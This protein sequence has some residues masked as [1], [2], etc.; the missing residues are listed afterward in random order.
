MMAMARYIIKNQRIALLIIGFIIP[1]ILFGA[2]TNIIFNVNMKYM[3][4][5]G[6]FN[7]KVDFVDLA[8]TFN[9]WGSTRLSD[10]DGDLIYSVQIPLTIGSV[11]QFKARINGLWNGLEEFP[12]GGPNRSY[13]VENNGVVSFWYNDQIPPEILQV[14]FQTNNR[15]VLIDQKIQ[16]A[17][18]T[19]QSDISYFW[20]LPGSNIQTSTES[21][22]VVSYT[23]PGSYPVNLKVTNKTGDTASV[24]ISNYIH[25]M[26]AI[27]HWWNDRVFYE[28]FVR[29]FYDSNGDGKGDLKGLIS[30]LDY[31][32]DGD[33]TTNT[34][35][36]ITGIW[37]M[38]VMQSPS[39]HGYDVTDYRTVETDY[40]NNDDFKAFMEAAHQRGIKVI[41]DLVMNHTSSQHPW[42]L[43][44][45]AS[46]SS[47]YRNWYRW[48]TSSP[49]STWYLRNGAYYYG[50][51]YSGMPDLNYEN[52][53]VK[54]EMFDIARYWL[55]DMNA[56]GFRLDAV[57]YIYESGNTVEDLPET[58]QFWKDFRS[59][60][61]TVNPEAFAVAEAWTST[62]IVKNYVGNDGLDFGFEF[63]LAS[64]IINSINSGNSS[65]LTNTLDEVT[66][67]Y[68]YL[69]YGTFLTNHDQE[70]IM[71]TFAGNTDK[72]KLAAQ[73]LLSLPGI[74]Y[75][76]YGEEIGVIGGKP[77]ENIR[78][79]MQWN[80][81]ANAGFST[82]TPWR[83]P[84]SD[85]LTKNVENQKKDPHSLWT[86]YNQYIKLRNNTPALRRGN[87]TNLPNNSTQVL[88]Y[89]RVY[90]NEKYV[91]AHNLGSTSLQNLEIDLSS[92]FLQTGSY[93]LQD[94]V[95]GT[96][97]TC[98]INQEGQNSYPQISLNGRNTA[99]F[100]ISSILDDI[101]EMKVNAPWIYPNPATDKIT[102]QTGRK[103]SSLINYKLLNI[104]GK[105]L[106]SGLINANET[107]YL[108]EISAG[109]YLLELV[110][111]E[112]R[113]T[114]KLIITK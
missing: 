41:V 27:T 93:T 45:S 47:P 32:N 78:T 114:H 95:S 25:V 104:S 90:G 18:I 20:T 76:Y 1:S 71:T 60:Y 49:S 105:V 12:G 70:R 66:A 75:L 86:T 59:H 64:S 15:S 65:A 34:D 33:S 58:F 56:D 113:S 24:S 22:P 31:L 98:Q 11:V 106:R 10:A 9:S 109:I 36:G 81:N 37:L 13:T 84:Q 29:S 2:T 5:L 7:P 72:A 96:S 74:P 94:I 50:I 110:D 42:F 28:V 73:I 100:R 69:Q 6:K 38:P 103:N 85:Y 44:S 3:E 87:Y 61:K 40:G 51:F 43:Q 80:S 17:A 101:N 67:S 107:I 99:I 4:M 68:P 88:S 21:S 55:E 91:I 46:A 92:I 63:S 19:N 82:S 39:Y 89:S 53:D 108:K 83:A 97:Y 14:S 8:G 102:I 48:S 30:K 79:P 26:E 16:L 57:K 35:L 52:N 62:S 23:T 77:D 111:K 112:I 54:A